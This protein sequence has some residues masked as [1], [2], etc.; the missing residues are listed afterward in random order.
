M[1]L[2][3]VTYSMIDGPIANISDFGAIGDGVNDDTSA[4]DAFNTWALT[5]PE[6]SLI[7]LELG[8]GKHYMVSNPWWPS[9][10][11]NLVVNGNGC[12]IQN[13]ST[14]NVNKS[15]LNPAFGFS[16]TGPNSFFTPVD[17]YFIN[18]V[19]AGSSSVTTTTASNAGNLSVGEMVCVG[20][21]NQQFSGGQ[22]P[23]LKYFEYLT[24]KSVNSSTG[25]I[26]FNENLIYTHQSD[27]PYVSATSGNVIGP[28]QVYKIE[29]GSLFNIN[30]E[31]NNINFIRNIVNSSNATAEAVYC[32]GNNIVFN[33]C[34]AKWFL[35][36]QAGTATLNDCVE[37]VAEGGGSGLLGGELDKLV[38]NYNLNGGTYFNRLYAAS[39][40]QKI[41]INKSKIVDNMEIAPFNLELNDVISTGS[42]NQIFQ[43]YSKMDSLTI[44]GGN[45]ESFFRYASGP[46]QERGMQLWSTGVTWDS[47][48][49]SATVNLASVNDKTKQFVSAC[50]VG[51]NVAFVYQSGAG[52]IAPSGVHGIV[53][54][55]T[56]GINSAT[57][58]FKFNAV[59]DGTGTIMVA[60]EPQS[61]MANNFYLNNVFVNNKTYCTLAKDYQ[62]EK[63]WL[64]T[65]GG[66][67]ENILLLGVWNRLIV[68]VQ[69]P[70]TGSTVG[71]VQLQVVNLGPTY[72]TISKLID[73]KTA[74]RREITTIGYAGITGTDTSGAVLPSG[75]T[76][77]GN[78]LLGLSLIAPTMASTADH[79]LPVVSVR[80]ETDD[81]FNF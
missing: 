1:P 51:A 24:V 28:A 75:S 49:T 62:T 35:P 46:L 66:S 81:S 13:N 19:V 31:Y 70:Y 27:L 73:L 50:Y 47:V 59:L 56:G 80:I 71:N 58:T 79:E 16:K 15:L 3:K 26:T 72:A 33:S 65:S 25:V 2:T 44:N 38:V 52:W 55:I 18:T 57:I 42:D 61:V 48:T 17:S 68:D 29:Q 22:P 77:G 21:F 34:S 23:N 78:Y 53:T 32:I 76:S 67:K 39:G 45:Y 10:I 12:S 37:L 20:S 6:N 74:G 64:V 5:F 7:T 60:T 54:A 9:N 36:T 69:R 41:T 30:H 63:E 4:F 8:Q 40:I 14:V 43:A 11:K